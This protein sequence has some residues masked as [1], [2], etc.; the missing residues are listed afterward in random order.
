MKR[1]LPAE[2]NFILNSKLCLGEVVTGVAK[3]VESILPLHRMAAHACPFSSY[4][5]CQKFESDA[6]AATMVTD[7]EYWKRNTAAVLCTQIFKLGQQPFSENKMKLNLS[8]ALSGH[9]G[10]P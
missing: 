8:N 5:H 4:S 2:K 7:R 6:A 1:T 9:V 10:C 3:C